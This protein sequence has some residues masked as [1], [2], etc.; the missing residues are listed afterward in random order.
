[1][2]NS[3]N[4]VAGSLVTVII[5]I[6]AFLFIK[7]AGGEDGFFGGL[8]KALDSAAGGLNSAVEDA[9]KGASEQAEK[10]NKASP[11]EPSGR[12]EEGQF[13]EHLGEASVSNHPED[14]QIVYLP[15]DSRGRAT[16]G[17]GMITYDTYTEA[18]KRGRQ[19]IKVNPSG[20]GQNKEVTVSGVDKDGNAER[21]HGWFYNRSHLIADSLGGHPEAD[22]LVTGTRMQNVG[23]NDSHGGMAYIETKVRNFVKD[24]KN[25]DC[26][27]YYAVTPNYYDDNELL[28]KTVTVNARSC[29]NQINEKVAVYN[30]APGYDIDY[31]NGNFTKVENNQ[32]NNNEDNQSD[33]Q[34]GD[35]NSNDNS[36]QDKGD[37]AGARK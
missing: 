7:N 31:T 21:Y 19:D 15:L 34:E 8:N 27:V 32:S 3:G 29:N 1:M 10:W 37:L 24:P 36:E 6:V 11:G 16:G 28:P 33:N 9:N 18:K 20:W 22:N 17:Y 12:Y 5:L 25:K 4:S 35:T 13:I 30:V 14:G 26:G 2:R 23:W